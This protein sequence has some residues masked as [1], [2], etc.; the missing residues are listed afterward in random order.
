MLVLC[1]AINAADW[2]GR[3]VCKCPD[4]ALVLYIPITNLLIAHIII[5]MSL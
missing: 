1:C 3:P 2:A 4:S 5:H